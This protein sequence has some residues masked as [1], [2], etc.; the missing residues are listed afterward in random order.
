MAEPKRIQL[1][2]S[3]GWRMPH[4]AV[5][6]DRSTMWGNP[7]RIG[8]VIDMK[9]ARRWGWAISP[10]GRKLVCE[11]A[12]EAVRRFG[13]ALHWDEAIHDYVRDQLKG[14]DLACWCA[15]DAPCHADWLLAIA[16]DSAEQIRSL[17]DAID[18]SNFNEAASVIATV[19]DTQEG[20]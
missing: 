13:H 12:S 3:A 17:H 16:N 10:A 9:M 2:R 19:R 8:E 6:V 7:Y 4:N 18:R 5:K 1:S 15:L 11:D 20:K 14:R